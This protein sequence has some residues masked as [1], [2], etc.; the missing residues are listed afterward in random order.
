MGFCFVKG[1]PVN[2]EST[3]ALIERIAFIRHTHYGICVCLVFA[4][5]ITDNTL[6]GFWDFTADLTFKDTAYTNEFLGAHT[7][8][9]YFTDPARLQLFHLLSHTDGS[10]GASLLV[11]GFAAAKQLHA[12]NRDYYTAL[13]NQR[14]PWHASGNEDVC[15]QPSAF[16]PV[17]SEHL[18]MNRVYQIRWNNYD[19]AP[20]V[21]W[22]L[23][24]QGTW[25]KAAR[26]Y[27]E[28]LNDM[29]RQI[30]TQLEPGTA[31]SK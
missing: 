20:K 8:N 26:R 25:Y 4:A 5:K 11:D 7:D 30:W 13:A 17:F 22:K 16:A 18:D 28:I 3:K 2:P 24:D 31:L 29:K 9:T 10:G 21:D 27:D 19:R 6:G 23:P 14:H 12:E 15:I 1:V